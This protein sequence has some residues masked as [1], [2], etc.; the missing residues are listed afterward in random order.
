[1]TVVEAAADEVAH[2]YSCVVAPSAEPAILSGRYHVEIH[3]GGCYRSLRTG[4]EYRIHD[5]DPDAEG[6]TLTRIEDDTDTE[7][8]CHI[9]ALGPVEAVGHAPGG[10]MRWERWDDVEA[11][12][13]AD[14]DVEGG[15]SGSNP[16][17]SGAGGCL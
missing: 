8:S 16:G 4:R 6:M 9:E 2:R 3:A 11:A 12:A 1:M 7:L 13:Q 14:P 15:I 10:E 17:S 5:L